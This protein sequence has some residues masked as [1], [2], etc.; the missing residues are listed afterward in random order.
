[1]KYLGLSSK[2]SIK[3]QEFLCRQAELSEKELDKYHKLMMKNLEALRKKSIKMKEEK[4][5][6][7]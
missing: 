2:Q 7:S 5:N 6:A 3:Y 4:R 1:M